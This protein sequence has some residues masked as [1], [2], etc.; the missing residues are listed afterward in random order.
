ML[1]Y[2]PGSGAATQNLQLRLRNVKMLSN[3]GT[4]GPKMTNTSKMVLWSQ[5]INIGCLKGH[6]HENS[7][8]SL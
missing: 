2:F 3:T 1:N 8:L 7:R 4:T 5:N 6:S